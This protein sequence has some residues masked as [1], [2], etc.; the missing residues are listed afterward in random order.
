VIACETRL[1]LLW[2]LFQN[3][4]Q[5]VADLAEL[6]E[7]SSQNATT[8]LRAL[9]AHGLIIP[10]RE[11]MKVFYRAK[12]NDASAFAPELLS[13]LHECWEQELPFQTIIRQATAFTHERRIEVIRAL[14]ESDLTFDELLE[15]T[16]MSPSS[17]SRHTAKL[18]A[19]GVIRR[20][21]GTYRLMPPEAGLGGALRRAATA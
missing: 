17:L 3:D 20:N 11:K 2:H 10:H 7:I 4:H 6:T 8:Q 15:E 9:N 1:Q 18:K 16:G 14:H 5:S 21:R 12:A 13:A 19:R